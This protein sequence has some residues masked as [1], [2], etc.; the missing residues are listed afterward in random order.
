MRRLMRRNLI[1]AFA[2]AVLVS[3]TPA[4]VELPERVQ[5]DSKVPTSSDQFSGAL[6][7]RF[8]EPDIAAIEEEMQI[9]A[10]VIEESIDDAGIED[11]KPISVAPFAT[12]EGIVG[13][14]GHVHTRYIPTVGA[15]FTIPVGFPLR[16][17]AKHTETDGTKPDSG[18]LWEKHRRSSAKYQVRFDNIRSTTDDDGN[19]R[20]IS[21]GPV[22]LQD[23]E[24]SKKDKPSKPESS[25]QSAGISASALA[26]GGVQPGGG[27]GGGSR[28]IGGSWVN[29]VLREYDAEKVAAFRE[30]LIATIAAYGHRLEHLPPEERVLIIVESPEHGFVGGFAPALAY[31]ND[32]QRSKSAPVGTSSARYQISVHKKDLVA[33]AS[34]KSI[35]PAITET[36]Y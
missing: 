30:R 16:S 32:L 10:K 17:T 13:Q 23:V 5:V 8:E 22:V 12:F 1:A 9:M 14:Q 24:D 28:G 15:I 2:A 4:Q 21:S 25:E 7:V 19:V 26:F 36:K 18:D 35:E 34:G 31:L 11:W 33:G 29:I 20:I 27:G 3:A 6:D